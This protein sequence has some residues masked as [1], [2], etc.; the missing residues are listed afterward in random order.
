M[1]PRVPTP[2]VFPPFHLSTC[3]TLR[4]PFSVLNQSI[5]Q[6]IYISSLLYTDKPLFSHVALEMRFLTSL[7]LISF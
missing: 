1:R 5:D 2:F 4:K 7:P 3:P 6:S